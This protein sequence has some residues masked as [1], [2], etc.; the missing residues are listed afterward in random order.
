MSATLPLPADSVV[1]VVD[2]DGTV[3]IREPDP[4][5]KWTGKPA[6]EA[7]AGALAVSNGC[8]GYA[9]VLGLDGIPR[10][11]AIEPLQWVGDKCVYVRVGLS[12]QELYGPIDRRLWRN[13]SAV[14]LFTVLIFVAVWIG[15]DRLILRRFAA[16]TAAAQRLGKGDFT[17][18]TDLPHDQDELG[19]LAATF[20][21]MASDIEAREK[22][23]IETDRA[24][25]RSNRALSVLSAGNRAM[26]RAADEQTLLDDICKAIVDR[27]GYPMAWVGY[28]EGKQDIRPVARGGF[29]V[30]QLDRRC[31]SAD[32]AR[33]GDAAPGAAIRSGKA[34][35]FR[36]GPDRQ[37]LACMVESSCLAALSFPLVDGKGAFG[38]LTIYA[39]EADAFDDVEI[40]LLA[41]AAADLAFGIGR[42]RDQ[43]LRREAENANRIKSEFLANMSHELRTP[44]N[45]IIG[46]S[47][48][49]KDGLA[50]ELSPR[51][52]EYV[53]DILQSGQH[54][55]SL[56][57]DILDLSKVEAGKMSLDLDDASVPHLLDNSLSVVREKASA[58]GIR[59]NQ[60]VEGDLP[61]IRVDIRKAKQVIYNLL[62][63]AIKFTPDGGG[64]TLRARRV[65]RATV[66]NWSSLADISIR[67]P[68]PSGEIEE[69]LEM[70]VEDTGIGIRREDAPRLF[71]PF[72]QIDS[73]LARRHE[74]TG[75]GLVMVTKLVGLHGG[76]VA[77]DSEPGR[78]SRFTV[79]LPWRRSIG[80]R[81]A[82]DPAA[83][84]PPSGVE[85]GLALIVEDDDGAANIERIQLEAEGMNTLRVVSGEEALA[86]MDSRMPAVIVLDVLLP[87]M[88]GWE[89]LDRIKRPKSCWR[90]VPVVIASVAADRQRGFSLGA[91]HVLQKPV[92]R[93]ELA[94]T[95]HR[96]GLGAKMR[97]GCTVLIVD[98]DPKAIDVLASYLAE[99]G[100][101][102]IKAT[103]GRQGIDAA[104]REKPH[105]ILLD[106]MMPE[107]NGFD[108]VDALHKDATTSHIPIIVVTAKQLSADDRAT[109]N[110]YVA[111]VLEKSSFNHGRFL[112]EVRRAL[113]I[114]VPEAS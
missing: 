102:T 24:L 67:L 79:W 44:L 20:D 55:L 18:R 30:S 40:E 87:G 11:S 7:G 96:L 95:L 103:G 27:G 75:L 112:N 108:V 60:E 41:E 35:L 83:P 68:L 17:A 5:G 66:E 33:S 1:V 70:S 109:L 94:K 53:L 4:E 14:A 73:S 106:L 84:K 54:L 16:L 63:N 9:E 3:L 36:V 56:I 69:F 28:L 92:M 13:L 93:E 98:D 15:G 64:V 107:V 6:P 99:S 23:I 71:Q 78:G 72:S 85:P 65:D 89:F 31:L 26:L 51:Q 101:R 58:H 62:S 80:P 105:L 29:Q 38:A 57:N 76:T 43:S 52:H 113:A 110:G 88:G 77:V 25:K 10:L 74:G 90:D 2:A 47:D 45:A 39:H 21:D 12:K 49:L 8:R 19:Q 82:T 86:L 81:Q 22:L 32:A 50:G 34:A 61:E 104:R 46:F 59:L 114:G 37:P 91:A 48:V 100:C 97:N 111:A 42:M